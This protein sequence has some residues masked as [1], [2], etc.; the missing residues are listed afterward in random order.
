RPAV[1]GVAAGVRRA[2]AVVAAHRSPLPRA[3]RL[4]RGGRR[5]HRALR[6]G[7]APGAGGPPCGDRDL[8]GRRARRRAHLRRLLPRVR[9]LAAVDGRTPRRWS[10]RGR[11]PTADVV[12]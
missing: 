9:R 2:R 11:L 10:A 3:R 1:R 6:R 4:V 5:R 7:P 8:R 12:L